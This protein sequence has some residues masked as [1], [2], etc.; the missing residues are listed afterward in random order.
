MKSA[1]ES[2]LVTVQKRNRW[3]TNSSVAR[4]RGQ[5]IST[6]SLCLAKF[7]YFGSK[8]FIN[9]QKII[10]IFLGSFRDHTVI[11]KSILTLGVVIGCVVP[12]RESLSI[13]TLYPLFVEY[14]PEPSWHHT[15]VSCLHVRERGI[16]ST[17][18]AWLSFNIDLTRS[19]IQVF[20][21]PLI[22]WDTVE[23][24]TLWFDIGSFYSLQESENCSK[25][26][27]FS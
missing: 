2:C 15:N 9:L 7:T 10:F 12:Y 1:S 25:C 18:L 24:W 26:W 20:V 11:K 22:N 17:L 27:H 13:K 3:S 8:L 4:H 23:K 14:S 19:S 5:V 16:A 6:C 21:S